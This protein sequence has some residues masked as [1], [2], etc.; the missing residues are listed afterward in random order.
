MNISEFNPDDPRLTA[1][2]LGEMEPAERAEFEQWLRQHPDAQRAVEDIRATAALLGTALAEEPAGPGDNVIDATA[3]LAAQTKTAPEPVDEYRQKRSKLLRF[4]ALYYMTASL[5]AACFTVMFFTSAEY[6]AKEQKRYIEMNE[7][8]ASGMRAK[9]ASAQAAEERRAELAQ[10]AETD[11]KQRQEFAVTLALPSAPPPPLE[12]AASQVPAVQDAVGKL[13]Q[14]KVAPAPAG[15]AAPAP[16]FEQSYGYSVTN[17]TLAARAPRTR[18]VLAQT[19]N[20]SASLSAVNLPQTEPANTEGYAQAS[21]NPFLTVAQNPLS[22]FSVDVDTASY[23]NVRRFLRNKHLPP[24]AAVRI[25]ELVNYFPYRYAPPSGGAP[26]AAHMEVASAPWAPEHRLVRIGL[27]GR[28]VS[29]AARPRANLVFLLDVSGSMN[30]PNKLPL[31]QQSLRLLVDK[32]RADDRVA[33]VVYAGASGLALPST[34]GREKAKI[35]S[36]I[37]ALRAEGSTNG[38][39]G[40]QLAYDIAKANFVSGGVNRV[41]LATDGDFNVGVS[42]EGELSRL[43]QEKAK[44]GVFLSVLGFGMGNYKDS[45]LEKLADQGNGNYAYIDSLA[46]AKK[47]LVEQAGGTLV[48]IAKDVKL[49]VEFNPAVAQAYR[50]IGYE[51]RML[52]KEDFNNDKIDAGEIGA[53]H[54]VTALYEVIPVGVPLPEASSVDALKY[55]KTAATGGQSTEAGARKAVVGASDE[56]LTLKVRYKEPTGDVSSK[57]EFPLRDTGKAFADASADFKFAAAVASFGMALKNSPFRG[58]VKLPE[59]AQWAREGTTDDAGG[60]RAEFV[61]LVNEASTLMDN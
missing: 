53:G 5:A 18:N 43:I 1:Y 27:K 9:I 28:E 52:R 26:F 30:E 56:L 40:I 19:A 60:Y 14:F 32:L 54:T 24:P 23:A 13:E 15:A 29:D 51:N 36:A 3:V 16:R 45:T 11:A 2:A 21:E 42:S 38:A 59:I 44:S 46:E 58:E 55:Q 10:R 34:P 41:V 50:L 12:V 47:T 31:V 17:P 4:P 8:L 6:Q 57:L 22:T 39:A 37:D 35:L 20:P 33:I 48:T 61:E 49:Q 25:E 7:S